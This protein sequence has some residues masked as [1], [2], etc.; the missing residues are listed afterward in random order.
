MR[1]TRQDMIEALLKE[2]KT[3]R[4]E[5]KI[6][7]NI[8]ETIA[9]LSFMSKK[10][11]K[12]VNNLIDDAWAKTKKKPI[13]TKKVNNNKKISLTPVYTNEKRIAL[14]IET[15]G[16]SQRIT[17]DERGTNFTYEKVV[18]T[19]FGSVT[20]KSYFSNRGQTDTETTKLVNELLEKFLPEFSFRNNIVTK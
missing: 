3:N 2:L 16:N 18:K 11:L 19:E 17:T 10:Q 7:K 5:K 20:T 12:R 8:D 6:L 15:P 14:Q 4:V 1:I 9:G 13:F